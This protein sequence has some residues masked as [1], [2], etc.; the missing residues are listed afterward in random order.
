MEEEELGD[1]VYV[2]SLN[3]THQVAALEERGL[4]WLQF[5]SERRASSS[6]TGPR[7]TS[8]ATQRSA[9][10]ERVVCEGSPCGCM[11]VRWLVL[12][13]VAVIAVGCGSSEPLSSQTQP[14]TPAT[15]LSNI[16]APPGPA[17]AYSLPP[18]CDPA[19]CVNNA[20]VGVYVQAVQ[21]D[22]HSTS[23]GH[24]A[25][26][27]LTFRQLA[28]GATT[29]NAGDY[30]LR[31]PDGQWRSMLG[32]AAMAPAGCT[33]PDSSPAP[34]SS[35]QTYGPHPY[36]FDVAGPTSGGHQLLL[37]A[38]CPYLLWSQLPAIPSTGAVYQTSSAG[39]ACSS[40]VVGLPSS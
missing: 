12:L 37:G 40:V 27:T 4:R 28:H 6:S 10:R 24:L 11:Q 5:W 34:L 19:P 26:V 1:V 17:P 3:G 13:A 33:Q 15:A 29:V 22:F 14:T 39:Q 18:L 36:C 35:A 8:S 32:V 23:D 25:R 16:T 7:A 20:G 30:W 2:A 21:R 31:G 38:G 9:L